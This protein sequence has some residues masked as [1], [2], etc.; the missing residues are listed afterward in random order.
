MTRVKKCYPVRRDGTLYNRLTRIKCY[1]PDRRDGTLH[2]R[3]TRVNVIPFAEMG[4]CTLQVD[5]FYMKVLRKLKG[6][7]VMRKGR[8]T[9][10]AAKNNPIWF[11]LSLLNK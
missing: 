4:P 11:K 2:C 6:D 1:I 9:E 8:A 3:L 10:A 7:G 5:P